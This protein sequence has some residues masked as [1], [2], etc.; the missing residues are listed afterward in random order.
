MCLFLYSPAGLIP[1]SEARP[2]GW[3]QERMPPN[4]Y[5]PHHSEEDHRSENA[6]ASTTTVPATTTTT[7]TSTQ[8]SNNADWTIERMDHYYGPH[9]DPRVA[10]PSRKEPSANRVNIR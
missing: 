5:G 9:T 10:E 6:P 3:Q 4:W 8:T 7:T 2:A 1:E